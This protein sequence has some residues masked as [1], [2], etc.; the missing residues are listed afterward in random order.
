M[1][2]T[3][4]DMA[5]RRRG[6]VQ[7]GTLHSRSGRSSGVFRLGAHRPYYTRLGTHIRPTGLT[8]TKK[9]GTRRLGRARKDIQNLAE[10]VQV[11]LV[12]EAGR[13]RQ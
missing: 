11:L 2:H 8:G 3:G 6:A 5:V 9:Q 13:E 7:R 10:E 12:D 1:E 4:H